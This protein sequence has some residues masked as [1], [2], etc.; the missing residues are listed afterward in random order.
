ME[1][2]LILVKPDGVQR[3]LVGPIIERFER[4]G[5]K[6][7]GLKLVQASSQLAEQHYAEHVGKPFFN[8][9]V[10][11]ITSRPVVAMVLQGPNVIQM[12]RN[13]IGVTK[14]LEAAPGTV[15]GDFGTDTGRNLV[16]ASANAEDAQRE[17]AL[18]FKDGEIVDY[19]RETDPWIVEP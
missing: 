11:F 13:T 18:W 15:R 5:I 7:V 17:L 10:S 12:C 1:R 6:I 2:T 14:P 9:L 8:G 3:G 4:R 16:H 19:P